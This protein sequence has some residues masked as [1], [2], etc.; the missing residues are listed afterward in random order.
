MTFAN[1]AQHSLH[2]IAETTYGTTPSTPAFSPLPHT[3]TTLNVSKDAVE[4]E[5]LR[6]DRQVE[7]F[8]HGNKTVGGEI[9]CELEYQ[10]FDDIIEAALCG[11][12]NSD[13]LKA[14]TTRRSFTL[15]RKFADLATAEFHTY[16]GCEINS[17]A[18]SVSPN[19]MVGCTFG[20]V[21]QD[22]S[23]ATSAIT[24]STFG[25]DVGETPFDSFTGSISEG[26]SSIA[27]VTSIEFTLENGIEPLFSVGSQTTSRPAIGR[28]RVTG[29]LTTYFESKTLY[30]K[31]LNETSSSITL[32]LAD[33]DGNEYEFDFSN[34]KYNSGQPDVSGEGAITIAMDFVALYDGTDQSQIKITRTTA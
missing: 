25:S 17:M 24:G 31:F 6:G 33:L 13:V 19:A 28:S 21:G 16:K 9:S 20:V 15:Q 30:E 11:T 5:K 12:W 10:A 23:I 32:T 7:D 34:V 22:L 8:R 27:T 2:Y 29:T 1:G 14:G 26:G 18:I 4:S 3:G